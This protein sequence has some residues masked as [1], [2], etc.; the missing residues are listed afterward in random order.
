MVEYIKSQF[1]DR[2]LSL[3]AKEK[4]FDEPCLGFYSLTLTDT[5]FLIQNGVGYKKSS[6]LSK[7]KDYVAAPL[8]QQIIDWLKEK[9]NMDISFYSERNLAIRK[10][11]ELIR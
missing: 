5:L 1:L 7:P 2:E 6:E 4:G 10:A 3:L 8:Y 11:L 9:H